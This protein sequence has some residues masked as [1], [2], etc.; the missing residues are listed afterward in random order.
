MSFAGSILSTGSIERIEVVRG[1]QSSLWGSDAV[2]AVVHI[3]TRSGSDSPYASAYAEGGSN[4]TGNIGLNGGTV[5]G[6]WR[7]GGGIEYL[8]T[9]GQNISRSGS[10]KDGSD[11]TTASLT[12]AYDRNRSLQ[13]DIAARFVDAYSQFDPVDFVTTGLPT[14]ADVATD[15]SQVYLQA[16]TRLSTLDGRITHGLRA[17][18]FETTNDNST[19]GVKESST[20]SDRLHFAYQADIQAGESRLAVALEH[21]QTNFEQRG[22]VIF[23]D[24]NQDQAFDITSIIADMQGSAFE[25]LSWFVSA[26]FDDNSDFDDALTGRLSLSYA[27]GDATTIRASVG[28]G[29][30]NPTF[31]ERFGFFP[32]QFVGNPEL[33]PERAISYEM[34]VDQRLLD[35][36]LFLQLSLFQSDLE[37]EI[38]G[39]VFDPVTFLSTADNRAGDSNRNGVEVAA[40]WIVSEQLTV[41]AAYTYTDSNA[42]DASGVEVRELRRPR[43]TGSISTA[44]RFAA[45]RAEISVTADYSGE[46]SDQF[47]PPFPDPSE[48]VTLDD[49]WL[50]DM[51]ANFRV[52]PRTSLFV[53]ATNLL[54]EDYE[55]VYG[56]RTLGRSLFAGVRFGFGR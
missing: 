15:T 18:Y 38:N 54:D 11:L 46:S 53:R 34:G 7:I 20:A 25:R 21:E 31:T 39:F 19:H 26:R 24:P 8:D 45:E 33:K 16:G 35:N 9:A 13:F 1:P 32:G 28:S 50:V 22:E 2:A 17:H 14:D 43:H 10:E 29:Q 41:A 47:F 51:N 27:V 56:Y 42:E 36:R 4:T 12:A 5:A 30:K 6:N 37:D 52:S 44:Y 40:N 48:I 23:G 3:I 55:Q 49:F